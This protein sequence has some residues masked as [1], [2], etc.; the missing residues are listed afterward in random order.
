MDASILRDLRD[1]RNEWTNI[2]LQV[3]SM[4]LSLHEIIQSQQR[5]I[6]SL[7]ATQDTHARRFQ[8]TAMESKI[9]LEKSIQILS[10][11]LHGGFSEIKQQLQTKVDVEDLNYELA[12]R[13]DRS[14]FSTELDRRLD[15]LR[16]DIVMGIGKKLQ[17]KLEES[18]L[19]DIRQQIKEIKDQKANF[20]D[21][22]TLL[23]A[24]TDISDTISRFAE[25]HS[26]LRDKVN[27]IEIT[28]MLDSKAS[29]SDLRMALKEKADSK[30]IVDILSRKVGEEELLSFVEAHIMPQI[31]EI[32][33]TKPSFSDLESILSSKIQ[34]YLS[35]SR[36]DSSTEMIRSIRSIQQEMESALSRKLDVEDIRT[37]EKRILGE[38]SKIRI[39]LVQ[40][41]EDINMDSQ[42]S[43][44]KRNLDRDLRSAMDSINKRANEDMA[45]IQSLWKDE[46]DRIFKDCKE[47][48]TSTEQSL[49]E[50]IAEKPGIQQ[51]QE[52]FSMIRAD[53]DVL[54]GRID[55]RADL[56][57]LKEMKQLIPSRDEIN[58]RIQTEFEVV[59]QQLLSQND[60]SSIRLDISQL[61]TTLK[62]KA[63]KHIVESIAN[64]IGDIRVRFVSM[65]KEINSS[66]RAPDTL[67]AQLDSLKASLDRKANN[68]DLTS[69]RNILLT[70][71]GVDD[72]AELNSKMEVYSRALDSKVS[73][74]EIIAHL[75]AERDALDGTLASLSR[76][77]VKPLNL[78]MKDLEAKIDVKVDQATLDQ[79]LELSIKTFTSKMTSNMN[80]H[81][82]AVE[83]I[84]SVMENDMRVIHS[85]F[86]QVA[87]W[88]EA[89]KHKV[90]RA[91]FQELLSRKVEYAE[92]LQRITKLEKQKADREELMQ[93]HARD[94]SLASMEQTILESDIRGVLGR[95]FA[96][97][98]RKLALKADE[99]EVS[100]LRELVMRKVDVSTFMEF[101]KS[102]GQ[103]PLRNPTSPT[104]E[105][106]QST[107]YADR[108]SSS[109][110]YQSPRTS[111]NASTSSIV[112]SQ[113]RGLRPGNRVTFMDEAYQSN[114]PVTLRQSSSFLNRSHQ[115]TGD[116]TASSAGY[117][118]SSRHSVLDRSR[119]SSS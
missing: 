20:K 27:Q 100:D 26:Q 85:R 113:T 5:K 9:S 42:V 112:D 31:S 111:H 105:L 97:F 73:L 119:L 80:S 92:Y 87:V 43:D 95:E 76:E 45:S 103:I 50:M 98:Q 19:S 58:H 7:E 104:R 94:K 79:H 25:V 17:D 35:Q 77:I 39:S 99:R 63:D 57:A 47:L 96:E 12:G 117:A 106:H 72:M 65:S 3:R 11:E 2:Q 29:L 75:K 36:H 102:I 23:D 30:A 1:G 46:S 52:A 56:Q 115:Q 18:D 67:E 107:S 84:R 16:F 61:H 82:D 10:H 62:S 81:L 28:S 110:R 91:E 54:S 66:F 41:I 8:Q 15:A 116:Y 40:K 14:T 33:K 55:D 6:D 64:E 108:V 13:I 4:F 83:R 51:V 44:I 24:K 86:N 68:A 21:V 114:P 89:L 53:M 60:L 93:S 22:A 32:R 69:L 109:A 34:E 88:E 74:S 59:L 90:D 71:A 101:Q 48:I 118:N 37:I 70:K 38:M 78:A 49:L